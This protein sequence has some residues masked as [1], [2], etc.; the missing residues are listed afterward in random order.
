M[1]RRD[2]EGSDEIVWSNLP[3]LIQLD[4][5]T[6]VTTECHDGDPGLILS[7][8]KRTNHSLC[9]REDLVPA[10]AVSLLDTS[11]GVKHKGDICSVATCDTE[12][13]SS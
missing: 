1:R 11:R 9:K 5:R 2:R 3:V 4:N 13:D 7:H 10:I 6:N 12:K 8:V